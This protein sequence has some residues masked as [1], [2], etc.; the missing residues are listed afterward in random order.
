MNDID[1]IRRDLVVVHV[2]IFGHITKLP[3]NSYDHK[4]YP[5]RTNF[6]GTKVTIIWNNFIII[7]L[8]SVANFLYHNFFLK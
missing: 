2:P 6:Q 4:K 3:S 5:F 1:N 8:D 7:I